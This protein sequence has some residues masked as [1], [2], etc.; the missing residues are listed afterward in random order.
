MAGMPRLEHVNSIVWGSSG[1]SRDQTHL[2]IHCRKFSRHDNAKPPEDVA[3]GIDTA[4][5]LTA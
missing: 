1:F 5:I 3:G 4:Q 2:A